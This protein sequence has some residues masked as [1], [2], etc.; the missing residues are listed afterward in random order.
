VKAAAVVGAVDQRPRSSTAAGTRAELL[1]TLALGCCYLAVMGGH[2]YSIDG[3]LMYRQT[4]AIVFD[5]SLLF[6]H[7]ITWGAPFATSKYGLG[8]SLLYLPG[9]FLAGLF[10][11]PP[12]GQGAYDWRLFYSDPVYALGAAPVHALV[13]AATAYLVARLAARL[14]LGPWTRL[15]ALVAFGL[16]SPALVYAKGDF[17]QPLLGLCLAGGLNAALAYRERRGM[18]ALAAATGWLVFG[19][20]TRPVEGSLLLPAALFLWAWDL[21]S[22]RLRG[23]WA[24]PG[25]T[26]LGGY[27][28]A[29]VVSGWAYWVRFGNPLPVGYDPGGWT[30]PF[31]ISLPGLLLSPARGIILAFPLVLLAPLGLRRVW[32]AG[33]RS[34]VAALAFLILALFLNNVFWSAWWGSWSWG[35]RLLVP[36][37]PL[38]AVLG[39]AG[40]EGLR[41]E[42]RRWL[43]A[44][45]VLAGFLW[46]VP[47]VLTDLLA[48][49]AGTYDGP[50]RSFLPIAYPP[51]GAWA[52]LHHLRATGLTDN[53]GIDIIWLR[54]ARTT[55]D[56]SL[57]VPVLLGAA[58]A[59]LGWR[60]FQLTRAPRTPAPS[61]SR[62]RG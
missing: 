3:L 59:Y 12:V 40:A 6:A 20:L 39:A 51:L 2:L 21:D 1:A 44:A 50:G 4:V 15:L 46:A 58:A 16:G 14:G 41:A 31:W 32:R 47:G 62:T 48:G 35:P 45:L 23:G 55:G 8:L 52:F 22:R 61:G 7:P 57:A 37:L 26:L 27:L 19:V 17:S 24:V 42:L 36:A 5:H 28:L 9:V 25:A 18:G 13:A 53:T 54:L 30:A 10:A 34:E 11:S 38:L 49:Y 60:A 56:L 43:P 29:L 33:Y